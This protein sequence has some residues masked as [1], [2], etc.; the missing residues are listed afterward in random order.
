VGFDD[1]KL[2]QFFLP[3]FTTVCM[4][5]SELAHIAFQALMAELEQK[6]PS[7]EGTEYR[8]ET[9]LVLRGSTAILK[10]KKRH[11]FH[12]LTRI[13]NPT[14]HRRLMGVPRSA[15]LSISDSGII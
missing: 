10:G 1:I 4:S 6:T 8:L 2:A 5:Q 13:E 14:H 7:K 9:S 12:N 15:S 11:E 3:P